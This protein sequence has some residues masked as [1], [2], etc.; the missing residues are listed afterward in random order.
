MKTIAKYI[1]WCLLT[2][3]PL[4]IYGQITANPFALQSVS[5]TVT[6][7]ISRTFQSDGLHVVGLSQANPVYGVAVSGHVA[8]HDANNSMVRVTA[9]CSDGIEYLVYETSPLFA[10]GQEFDIEDVAM[11][12]S[13]LDAENIVKLNV[14]LVNAT[15]VLTDV[16]YNKE[17]V[18]NVSQR[19]SAVA[20]TQENAR[21]ARL[22][23]NL[24][25]QGHLWRAGKTSLSSMTYEQKKAIFGDTVPY[26]GGYEY[27]IGGIFVMPG[28]KPQTS[29]QV[30]VAVNSTYVTEWDWRNRH[31]K[32]W[33]TSVKNQGGYG[34]CWAFS[35][36][37]SI[38]AYINLY[39]NRLINYD[40]SEQ[41]LVS[42]FSKNTHTE[43]EWPKDA[44]K[45]IKENGIVLESCFPYVASRVSC[46][47]ICKNESERI[48]I[49]NYYEIDVDYSTEE[50]VKKSLFRA[51]LCFGISSWPHEMVLIGYKVINEGDVVYTSSSTKVTVQKGNTLIGSTAWLFKNSWG[52]SFGTNGYA[53]VVVDWN[54]TY[55]I[56]PISGKIKSKVF[57][58]ND[59]VVSDADGDGFYFWGIGDRPSSLPDWVPMEPD[60][61][62]SDPN[63]GAMDDY[64]NLKP[65]GKIKNIRTNTTWTSLSECLP[66][67]F[68]EKGATLTLKGNM[69]LYPDSRIL[70]K[71]G[72]SLI[73]DGVTLECASIKVYNGGYIK[74]MNGAELRREESD[75]FEVESGG[76][77]DWIEGS[78]VEK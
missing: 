24:E 2:F 32:N 42:C 52:T 70:V 48:Y 39:Y 22:N 37:G 76:L 45:Y 25:K 34:S 62:D 35:V 17:P 15:F 3:I 12:T 64:G 38:E 40:L 75:I 53:Y 77:M 67:V 47:N 27:Y 13:V 50:D 9:V 51:P 4:G 63:N 19:K 36:A 55:C 60:G 44:L 10:D 58:D 18:S 23:E 20:A 68:V 74:I 78:I 43:G 33:M 41:H 6:E 29:T 66:I 26:L 14:M 59:I 8:F 72:G 16:S 28:Y 65:S 21:I 73:L 56:N 11:E 54:D 57:S 7:R 46:D 69:C 30:K 71:E 61:D 5:K 49:E 31:G 1:G